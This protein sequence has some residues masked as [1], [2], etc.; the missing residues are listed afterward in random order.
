MRTIIIYTTV[1]LLLAVVSSAVSAPTLL[2]DV[3]GYG[4]NTAAYMVGGRY[5]GCGPTSATM[6]LDT[7]DSRLTTPGSLVSDPLATAW[8]LHHNYMNTNASG[9]GAGLD[10]QNGMVDYANDHGHTL[11]AVIHVE[12]STFNPGGWAGYTVGSN[13]ITD[14][15]FWDTT[16]SDIV[17]TAFI[18]FVALEIDAGDPLV[19]TVDSDG[20]GSDDHWMVCAGYDDVTKQWAGY[21]TWDS[22]LHW[23]DVES[24]FIAGNTMGVAFARTFDFVAC[25]GFEPQHVVPAPGALLL[26][27]M[28]VGVVSWLRR[29][30]AL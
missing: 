8:D 4:Y 22:S 27:G 1:G 13:L 26:G 16:T 15:T 23:Y 6:V 9:F 24:A 20:D 17:D 19:L 14:A 3:P 30:R 7:Y 21:N 28:G 5:V 29:R 11:D 18:G 25:E 10:L 12:P 2:T